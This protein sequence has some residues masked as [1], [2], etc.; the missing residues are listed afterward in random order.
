MVN[1]ITKSGTNSFHGSA[2]EDFRNAVLNA[3]NYFN[4]VG[5]PKDGF[6][7][8]QFGGTLGGPI[9]KDKVFFYASYEGQREGMAITSINN[10]PTL[11]D[12]IAGDPNDYTQAIASLGGTVP[13]TSTV[14][15][16]LT[17]TPT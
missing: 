1:I 7:N 6:R 8:N 3:R 9:V 13:C 12:G 4:D 2:F 16:A 11:N 15:P 14:V 10:V 17:R 5:Q